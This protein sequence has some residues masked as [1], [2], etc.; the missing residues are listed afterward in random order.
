MSIKKCIGV[1]KNAAAEGK[2]D[3]TAAMDILEE[4]NDFIDQAGSKNID[5]LDAKLQEH[6][7]AKLNDEILAA[8]IEKRNRALSAMAEVRA[9]RVIDSFDNPFEGIKALLAGSINANY[10]SKLSIDV[11]AKSLGNKYIG[12]IINKLEQNPGDLQLYNS[13]KIDMDIAKEMWEIKPDG[14][15]GV[16]KNAAARRIANIL[17]E[18]QMIAVKNANK[19]GS[20]IRPRAGYIMRQYHNI[21]TIRKAGM[22]VWVGFIKDKLD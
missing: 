6:I 9:M 11:S 5:N 1:I 15:P 21:Q 22:D 19:A 4:I 2:I 13:G 12:R 10:K 3:D 16:T 14:N 7:Q 20:F 17:H 8:T 18:S